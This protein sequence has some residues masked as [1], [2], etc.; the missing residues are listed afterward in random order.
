MTDF[1]AYSTITCPLCGHQSTDK[2]P[3][4]ACQFGYDCKGCGE[5]LRLVAGRR[6]AKR[7]EGPSAPT[8][9]A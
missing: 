9:K 4:D 1:I 2:M 6:H 8:G 3:T 7:T 5:L